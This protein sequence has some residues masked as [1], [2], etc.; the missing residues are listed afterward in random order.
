MGE[1][2]RSFKSSSFYLFIIFCN[3]YIKNN[4]KSFQVLSIQHNLQSL[5]PHKSQ[6][7]NEPTIILWQKEQNFRIFVAFFYVSR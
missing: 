3:E 7:A 6:L 1:F 4:C 5:Y 2:V